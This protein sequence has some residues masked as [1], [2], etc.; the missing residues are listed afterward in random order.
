MEIE[1]REKKIEKE[2]ISGRTIICDCGIAS[3]NF[4]IKFL[5]VQKFFNFLLMPFLM[6]PRKKIWEKKKLSN[7]MTAN[8]N[9]CRNIKLTANRDRVSW[10]SNELLV[11]ICVIIVSGIICWWKKE[12]GVGEGENESTAIKDRVNSG[13]FATNKSFKDVKKNVATWLDLKKLVGPS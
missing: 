11:I 7:E 6:M 2:T 3:I 1:K 12:R 4:E 9:K 10:R 13:T 5:I 8:Y